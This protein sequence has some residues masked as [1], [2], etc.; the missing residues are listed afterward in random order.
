MIFKDNIEDYYVKDFIEIIENYFLIKSTQNLSPQE[1]RTYNQLEEIIYEAL[2][3]PIK[4]QM[5]P[6]NHN[7]FI[8]VFDSYIKSV[9]D[10]L[11]EEEKINYIKHSMSK[12]YYEK[13]QNKKEFIDR[14]FLKRIFRLIER[15]YNPLFMKIITQFAPKNSDEVIKQVNTIEKK[16]DSKVVKNLKKKGLNKDEIGYCH[17]F[18]NEKKKILKEEYNIEWFTPAECNPQNRY[19]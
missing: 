13:T 1:K 15:Y 11:S 17:D 12:I 18:W 4:W 16:I 8:V 14:Y 19:D 9:I 5:F 3:N 10:N 7:D 2:T 6:E